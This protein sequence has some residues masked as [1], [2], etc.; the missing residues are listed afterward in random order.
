MLGVNEERFGS[1]KVKL[2]KE[3]VEY[4]ESFKISGVAEMYNLEMKA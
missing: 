4:V 1:L 2:N 3:R